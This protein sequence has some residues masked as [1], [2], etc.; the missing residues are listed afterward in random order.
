MVYIDIAVGL[1]IYHIGVKY[2][3]SVMTMSSHS[4]SLKDL[5]LGPPD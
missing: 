4:R 5:N 2:K 3:K 1:F